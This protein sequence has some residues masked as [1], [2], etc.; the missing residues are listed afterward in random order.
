MDLAC[1]AKSI[2]VVMKHVTRSGEPRIVQQCR[3]PLTA[4]GVVRRIYTDLAVIDLADGKLTVTET[5]VGLT[6]ATLQSLTGA[7]LHACPALL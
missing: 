2:W 3:Y 6:F 7:P 1:G 5:V 4:K